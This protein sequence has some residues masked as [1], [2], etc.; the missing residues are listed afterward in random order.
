MSDRVKIIIASGIYPP[1]IGG[2]ATYSRLVVREFIKRGIGVT[3]ICYSDEKKE[4]IDQEEKF[5]ILRI[6][7]RY[8]ILFRYWLYFWSLFNLAKNKDV[9]YAQG[10]LAAGFPALLV[11]KILRKKFVVKIVGDYAWEQFQNKK[12]KIK[13]KKFIDIETFQ[14]NKYDFLTELRRKIQKLVVKSADKIIVPSKFLKKIV[15]GWGV[16]EDKI[17][18]VYN[19]A[20]GVENVEEKLNP[21]GDIIISGGRLEPWKGMD[22]LIEIMPDLLKENPNFRLIIVGYGPEK[23]NL[24][25]QIS[26]L[27]LEDKIELIDKLS[28]KELLEYFKASKMFVLNTGYEG[29]SHF[30]LET[31]AIG[32][33]VITT[34]ICGNPEIVKDGYN[35]LLIEYNNKEQLKDTILRLWEDKKLREKFIENGKKTLGK[36]TLDKMINKTIKLLFEFTN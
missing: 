4:F 31:M 34:N 28:H 26:N 32:L 3:V 2:P 11:S 7:R 21:E 23:E 18:V 16:R 1:D 6:S 24:K 10:P 33:P 29:F 9:I 12:S 13:N 22:V 17:F 35:G 15:I 27:K 19:A 8:N 25:S 36:F 14:R 20:S 5:E 30:L